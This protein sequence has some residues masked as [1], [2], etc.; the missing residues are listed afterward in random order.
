[1]APNGLSPLT[2]SDL[3]VCPPAAMAVSMGCSRRDIPTLQPPRGRAPLLESRQSPPVAKT[4]RW[5][6]L[7]QALGIGLNGWPHPLGPTE[8][9][10]C[11]RSW[12]WMD[13]GPT[14]SR[15]GRGSLLLNPV[16]PPGG[17][18][19]RG[20]GGRTPSP[21]QGNRSCC[22]CNFWEHRIRRFLFGWSMKINFLLRFGAGDG[23]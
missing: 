12:G 9:H 5:C 3:P 15:A 13:L 21:P 6:T 14:E 2:Q 20:G 1:M 11:V 18:E 7:V 16:C 17:G 19:P 4:H 10:S 22:F 8:P 23:L